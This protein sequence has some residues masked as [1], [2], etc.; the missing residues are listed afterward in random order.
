[1]IKIL[2]TDFFKAV[3]TPSFWVISLLCVL[4]SFIVSFSLFFVYTIPEISQEFA[5]NQ[6]F[7]PNF[8]SSF[9]SVVTECTF[10]VG[11]F[12]LM[13]SVSDFSFGTI[14]NLA[15]KGYPREFIY[16]SKFI[17]SLGVAIFNV[18]L[19]F[20]TSFIT[21]QIMVNTKIQGFFNYNNDFLPELAKYSFKLVAYISVA[22]FLAMLIRSLGAS[23][24]IFLAFF[25]LESPAA[26]LI[27]KLISSVFNSS[28]SVSPYFISG[29]FAGSDQVVQSVIVLL[30]YIV[31][32]T[33]V[34]IFTFKQR[35]IN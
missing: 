21:A 29:T 18:V 28:F 12:T 2:K 7:T 6:L 15:S 22:I 1:M 8:F 13:F 16:F 32:T 26:I 27:N 5:Q 31:I 11:I 17:T 25:F 23:L 35:D 20:I 3:R 4:F 24:A 10:L 30:A 9:L 33:A 34:G 19:S 14:K